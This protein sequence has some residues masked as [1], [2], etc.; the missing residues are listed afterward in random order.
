MYHD[1]VPPDAGT[2]DA[3]EIAL[4]DAKKVRTGVWP[5]QA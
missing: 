5:V 1:A 2:R 3:G 4:N